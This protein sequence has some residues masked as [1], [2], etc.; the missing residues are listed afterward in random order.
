MKDNA[1]LHRSKINK[2]LDEGE[3]HHCFSAAKVSSS[4]NLN[5]I[6]NVW[7]V[8]EMHTYQNRPPSPSV[9]AS[10]NELNT[11]FTNVALKST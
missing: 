7:S 5:H 6:E 11:K 2:E 8:V 1:S 4:S 3:E 9:S 10:Q